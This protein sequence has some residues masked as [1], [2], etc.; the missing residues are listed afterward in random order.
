MTG[1]PSY[2]QGGD[3]QAVAR[4]AKSYFGGYRN[5]FL[6][7]K[8][9]VPGDKM[10]TKAPSLIVA[11]YGSIQAFEEAYA[12][13]E[14]MF[15]MD[16]IYSDPPNV[17]LTSFYGFRPEGWG[18]LGFTDESA[19]RAFLS[20]SRSGVLVVI[21]AASKAAK[22]EV[23]KVL[24]IIQCSH[25][26]GLAQ[27]YMSPV[28]WQRKEA[29]P[30][31]RGKWSHAIKAIRAWRVTP[32]SRPLVRDFA[33]DATATEA[34]QHI[35]ARGERLSHREALNILK[36]D[37][38]EVDVYGE[39]PIIETLAGTAREILAP[40]KAGPVSQSPHVTREAE[41]PKHLY[42]LKLAGDVDGFLGRSVYGRAIIKAGFSKS[43]QTRCDDHNRALPRGAYRWE[44]FRSGAA[45]RMAPYPTSDHAK[46][47]E[48]MMQE[49]LCRPPHGESLGGEF[50]L[51]STDLI[52]EAWDQGNLVAKEYKK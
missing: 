36:L 31:R 39:S 51:A 4:V 3:A 27:S 16:A 8:W 32:E 29:D 44:V 46:A 22:D 34:W 6:A 50:F 15:P 9:D 48:R 33:P 41:G 5:M 19:H 2:S 45:A 1:A 40:S 20:E 23:G 38:Q 52:E 7:H 47:G 17:W 21:Y 43:P 49:I 13:Q 35:G 42:V 10:M 12:P 28:E 30:E 26:T 18:F 25:V 11:E 14:N 24:G 37:L